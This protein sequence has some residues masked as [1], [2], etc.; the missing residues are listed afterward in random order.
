MVLEGFSVHDSRNIGYLHLSRPAR[1][2]TRD[3]HIFQSPA[4]L[5]ICFH[6][7]SSREQR[8]QKCEPIGDFR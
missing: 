8:V 5:V 7:P 1:V 6:Q 4:D 3:R 2:G